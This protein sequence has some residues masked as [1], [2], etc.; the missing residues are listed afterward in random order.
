MYTLFSMLTFSFPVS[1]VQQVGNITS[2]YENR[3]HSEHSFRLTGG[4]W[5]FH[6][7]TY[8]Y[9]H[10]HSL[11]SFNQN[12][13]VFIICYLHQI[14][15]IHSY[16]LPK[17]AQ[18]L[19]YLRNEENFKHPPPANK[20]FKKSQVHLFI[21]IKH[22]ILSSLQGSWKYVHQFLCNS[23][24]KQAN[25]YTNTGEILTFTEVMRKTKN[26]WME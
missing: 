11:R 23:A 10:T 6:M 16:P 26:N 2:K 19:N 1:F 22:Q 24:H 9:T 7:P 14:A 3:K 15:I 18:C 8:T 5:S 21:R 12:I 17:Y 25:K 20:G 13:W 4:K